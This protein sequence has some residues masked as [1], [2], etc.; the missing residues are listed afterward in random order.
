MCGLARVGEEFCLLTIGE[1][2][3]DCVPLLQVLCLSG[4]FIPMFTMYQNLSISQG[5]SD[6]FMW[7][8]L[9]QIAL[10]TAIILAFHGHGMF[11]MVC[12]YSAF[13]ILWL[14]P[15]HHFA[16]RLIAYR[17]TDM[18]RDVLPFTLTAATVM[19][20]THYATAMI[21]NLLLLITLRII[22]AALLYYIIMR[23]AGAEILKECERFVKSKISKS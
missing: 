11:T 4:A 14:L 10:Q 9:V 12:A 13:L 23:L 2:W 20:A 15:W 17:W 6:V 3:R 22:L 7:L 19:A 18:A 16:G 8:N 1:N 5:R 21:E